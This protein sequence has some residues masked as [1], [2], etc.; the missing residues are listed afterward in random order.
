L[1]FKFDEPAGNGMVA[2]SGTWP[3]GAMTSFAGQQGVTGKVGNAVRLAAAADGVSISDPNDNSLDGFTAWTV[4]GWINMAALPVD[5]YA[6]LVKKNSAYMCRFVEGA[7]CVSCYTGQAVTFDGAGQ[8][9][10]NWT[11]PAMSAPTTN[12]WYHMACTYSGAGLSVYWNGSL[13]TTVPG[14]GAF[15][16]TTVPLGIGTGGGIETLAGMIDEVRMWTVA[17]TPREICLDA[18]G[19]FSNNVCTYDGVCDY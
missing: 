2:N 9:A 13:M 8:H 12:T 14:G 6:T 17:R 10:A 11:I 7:G 19:S 5:N 3:G 1:W 4:E 18:C 16:N 15:T